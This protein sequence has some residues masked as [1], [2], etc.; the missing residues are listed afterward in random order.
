MKLRD[1][2]DITHRA[3]VSASGF[4]SGAV[5]KAEAHG[6]ELFELKPWTEPLR[7]QF[8][9]FANAGKPN[10]FFREFTSKLLCWTD[11][12]LYLHVPA[13]P[14]KFHYDYSAALYAADGTDHKEYATLGAFTDA[15]VLRSTELLF[16]SL[17]SVA[18]TLESLLQ[19][20]IDNEDAA[21]RPKWPHSHTLEVAHDQVFLRFESGL[22]MLN[23]LTIS[24]YLHWETSKREIEFYILEQVPCG[25]P[26]AAAA[27]A[28]W[29]S[30]DG[31]MFAMVFEPDSRTAGVHSFRLSEKHRN[32]IRNL[33]IPLA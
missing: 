17:P 16:E 5:A 7:V 14:P 26:F 25:G 8:P 9:E 4:S 12:E 29:G 15:L 33:K 11:W 1:M 13:G 2:P 3:I 24:G 28:E 21:D 27:V 31:K 22:A 23:S 10:E 18:L 19:S 32:A 6:V 20:S 30:P